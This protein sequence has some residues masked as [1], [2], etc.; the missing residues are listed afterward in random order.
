[1]VQDAPS[2]TADSLYQTAL[3]EVGGQSTPK[4][5]KFPEDDESD[6]TDD[7]RTEVEDLDE[8]LAPMVETP[9]DIIF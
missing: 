8:D 6:D 7:E 2:T 3:V 1:M 4:H 5:F 9:A